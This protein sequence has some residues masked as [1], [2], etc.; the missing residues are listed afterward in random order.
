MNDFVKTHQDKIKGVLSGF[1]RIRFR[2]TLRMLS[3]AEGL[4]GW[5]WKLQVL[6]MNFREW[7]QD[8]TDRLR[9]RADAYA[10]Q[11]GRPVIYVSS[12]NADKEAIARQV[13]LKDGVTSG[14]VCVLTCVESCQTFEIHKNAATKKLELRPAEKRCLHLYFYYIHPLFGWSHVRVQSW[15]PFSVWIVVNGREWLSRDLQQARIDFQKRE[16]CIVDVADVAAAQRLL[17]AQTQTDWAAVLGGWIA[18]LQVLPPEWSDMG[19]QPHYWSA[20]ETEVATDV[21]FHRP[22]ELAALYPSLVQHVTMNVGCNDV[23]RYFAARGTLTQYSKSEIT[24]SVL[25][26]HEETR[27]KHFF[28]GNSV[29]I[30]DKQEFVLRAE[31]TIN[32]PD[33]MTVYRPKANDPETMAWQP[34]RKG[35][36][37]L[38][39]RCEL[40]KATNDRYL[41]DLATVSSPKR[42]AELTANGCQPV[43]RDGRTVRA[44]N[45][46]STNDAALLA[47]VHRGEFAI[48]GFRNQDI[49]SLL[50]GT[51]VRAPSTKVGRSQ[52]NKVT[53]LLKLLRMHGIIQKVSK[54]HRYQLTDHGR[55]FIT[56]IQSAQQ[57][58]V[59]QLAKLAA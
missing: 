51:A 40:S 19:L 44:L 16:N 58:S 48:N 29:K 12:C 56:A 42:L 21:M 22:E 45:P 59:E 53:R 6:L 10:E 5:L 37:D 55:E 11:A 32:N 30:Y 52:S 4:M 36:A 34:M 28:C 49:R 13:A 17:D 39:R 3:F 35:I 9:A 14:L 38:H 26:R 20:D 46:L 23:L 54:T 43:K 50:F 41:D 2:G 57:A 24:T 18:E 15:L 1:D 33:G 8:L 31:T 25:T 7:S 27:C 47:A